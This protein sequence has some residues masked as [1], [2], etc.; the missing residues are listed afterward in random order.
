MAT[1]TP[2]PIHSLVL[3]AGPIIKN[4]PSVST[5]LG[6]AETLYTIPAV[7]DEI[8]DAVTRARI[9][10]TLLPFLTLRSPRPASVKVISDFARKT[11]DLEV[12]SRPDIHLMALAYELECERNHGGWRLRSTPG[13]KGLNGVKPE[14]LKGDAVRGTEEAVTAVLTEVEGEKVPPP[15]TRGA[16]GTTIPS[17]ADPTPA[18]WPTAGG[19]E[20]KLKD[21]HISSLEQQATREPDILENPHISS[22]ET[23]EVQDPT[24]ETLSPTA[25]AAA[26]PL[27]P[28]DPSIEDI[29]ASDNEGSDNEGWITPSNLKKHQ[30]KDANGSAK[31]DK[32][33]MKME[34]VTVTSDFAM[35]NVLL[36]MNLNLMSPNLQRIRQLKNW[37]LRCHACFYITKDIG[38]QFCTRC[39]KPTLLRTSCSTDKDGNFKVHLK[40]NMQWNTR[41]N[42]YSIPKP[43]AGTSNGKLVAGGGKGGWGQSLI[44]AEDQKEYIQAMTGSRR[45]KE[46]D[47]MDEDYLPNLLS[48]DRGRAGGRPKV[49]A[50]KNVNS[51]KRR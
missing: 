41:G 13:Q 46:K 21:T 26:E 35:Q 25:G 40:K 24:L 32:A 16:W 50:G 47:L 11:G 3:D 8:R 23:L 27:Q 48:G 36:R 19:L 14:S 22:Q 4:E 10:N 34:V 17:A 31:P 12:L 7:I 29:E 5:L 18:E 45:N 28:S 42:V 51:K 1:D 43:V 37:V 20:E 30:E 9:E 6:Q 44:L 49:G 33:P 39:G 38:K 2:K 15:E